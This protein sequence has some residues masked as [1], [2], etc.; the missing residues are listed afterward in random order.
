MQAAGQPLLAAAAPA[1]DQPD[2]FDAA[3]QHR[4]GMRLVTGADGPRDFKAAAEW[5]SRSAAQGHPEGM[6]DYALCQLRGVGVPADVS[7]AVKLL[8]L[9]AAAG[10]ARA[11]NA[12]GVVLL[13]GNGGAPPTV[14][15]ATRG[16][17]LLRKAA[18]RGFAPAQVNV[19]ACY[20]RGLGVPQNAAMA[21]EWGRR[22]EMQQQQPVYEAALDW[23]PILGRPLSGGGSR[24]PAGQGRGR[25]KR[26]AGAGGPDDED[27]GEYDEGGGCCSA[28]VVA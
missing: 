5:L 20:A 11:M 24:P 12:L 19:A 18:A 1:A 8:E 15:V 6:V 2:M 14:A 28:C 23:D 26:P 21:S 16:A 4:L 3:E 9:G 10:N 7:A 22:A 27:D 17:D 13:S 25:R